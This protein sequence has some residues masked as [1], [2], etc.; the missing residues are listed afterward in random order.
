MITLAVDLAKYLALKYDYS[1]EDPIAIVVSHRNT[2][3]ELEQTIKK[4]SLQST[5][6]P[7]R[8]QGSKSGPLVWP[9]CVDVVPGQVATSR[10]FSIA[11]VCFADCNLFT[12]SS[13]RTLVWISRATIDCYILAPDTTSKH[14]PMHAIRDAKMRKAVIFFQVLEKLG[15]EF[16]QNQK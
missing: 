8:S 1:Q 11:I 12:L 7:A 14:K 15:W 5:E 9:W 10:T 16:N 2:Q 4:Q 3:N 13:Y 6:R